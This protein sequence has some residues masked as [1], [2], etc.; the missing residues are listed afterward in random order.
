[1]QTSIFTGARKSP[2][3]SL[4]TR[5]ANCA[6]TTCAR[7]GCGSRAMRCEALVVP[8]VRLARDRGPFLDIAREARAELLR[9]AA[10]R[11]DAELGEALAHIGQAHDTRHLLLQ[12][13]H[14]R[15]RRARGG[16]ECSP[17]PYFDLRNAGFGE[18]RHVG[19][20]RVALR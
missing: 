14:D 17:Q 19:P 15:G 2:P 18:R 13:R 6:A 10:H 8:D 12:S 11:V 5:C 20:G 1:M 7:P 4:A 3:I 9:A 16:E